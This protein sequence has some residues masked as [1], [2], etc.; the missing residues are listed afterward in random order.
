MSLVDFLEQNAG[1]FDEQGAAT[2]EGALRDLREELETARHRGT[3]VFLESI[4]KEGG[5]AEQQV[6]LESGEELPLAEADGNGHVRLVRRT[7][8]GAAESYQEFRRHHREVLKRSREIRS[9]EY[10]GLG[11][12]SDRLE[13]SRMATVRAGLDVGTPLEPIAIQLAERDMERESLT[14]EI[15]TRSEMVA[16]LDR[17]F[18]QG[19]EVAR[20][21]SAVVAERNATTQEE[22]EVVEAAIA[23]LEESIPEE[24]KEAI[25]S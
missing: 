20:L 24:G 6:I 18:G 11:G 5:T 19:G 9:I 4:R 16:A 15:E 10:H 2:I 13:R 12:L 7:S 22:I 25:D 17:R 23:E 8:A 14:S 1:A 3:E 21:V